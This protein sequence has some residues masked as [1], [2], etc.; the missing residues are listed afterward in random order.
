[1]WRYYH[2]TWIHPKL[3]HRWWDH[4][5][6]HCFNRDNHTLCEYLFSQFRDEHNRVSNHR[7][8]NCLFKSVRHKRNNQTPHNWSIVRGIHLSPTRTDDCWYRINRSNTRKPCGPNNN[9]ANDFSSVIYAENLYF[10][11]KNNQTRKISSGSVDSQNN[12]FGKK[13]QKSMQWSSCLRHTS[14]FQ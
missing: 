8:I 11:C 4:Q 9:I 2:V 10:R 5:D 1:M 14:R 6:S 7:Q 12:Y 13:K 3:I